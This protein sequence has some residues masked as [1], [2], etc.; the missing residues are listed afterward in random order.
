MCKYIVYIFILIFSISSL[1]SVMLSIKPI[2]SEPYH[3]K[4]LYNE[5]VGNSQNNLYRFH[6]LCVT[7]ICLVHSIAVCLYCTAMF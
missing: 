3:A 6:C 5:D 1:A 4:I 7:Y 2:V